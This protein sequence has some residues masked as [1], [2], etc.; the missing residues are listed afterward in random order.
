VEPVAGVDKLEDRLNMCCSYSV[1]IIHRDLKPANIL[2]NRNCDIKI[3]DFGLATLVTSAPHC[4][5]PLM[6]E[7]VAT[8][9]YRA[10][11]VILLPQQYTKVA[12][13]SS[14]SIPFLSRIQAI[15]MWAVGCI[16][17]EMPISW[18]S[19]QGKTMRIS[20]NWRSICWVC[21]LLLWYPAAGIS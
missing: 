9:W 4:E 1:G 21:D 16:L 3:C 7:Y 17:A 12:R 6:T 20:F 8:R 11:E 10:P 13:L 15:D 18:R 5:H 14:P 2:V 19:Y